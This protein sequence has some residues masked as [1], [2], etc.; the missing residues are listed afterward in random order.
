MSELLPHYADDFATLFH[1]DCLEVTLPENCVDTII[2]DPPYGLGFMG[3]GWDRGVPGPEFWQ[4]FLA[5]TKPGGTLLAF[6]GT[7][8]YHRLASAIEDAGWELRDCLMW[9]YGSGFPKSLDISKALDA[10][11]G[12]EREVVGKYIHP[13]TGKEHGD[14]RTDNDRASY[15]SYAM[16]EDERLLTAPA[17]ELAKLW[18]GYGTA[19]KPAWEPII[20][21]MKP[22]E[23]TFAENAEKWGVAGL[24]IDGARIGTT[25]PPTS[26]KD[27]SRWREMEGRTDSQVAQSDLDTNKGRWPANLLLDEEAAKLLGDPAR[28]FYCAKASKAE[29]EAGLEQMPEV[30]R[31]DGREKDIEN[32]RLRTSSRKNHHPTVKPLA[33]ME[34]LCTLTRTPAGGIVFD[35]FCGS[36]STLI[37]AKRVGRESIGIEL[38]E[39]YCAI[40]A[41]RLRATQPQPKP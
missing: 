40:G 14:F 7:R 26:A 6:G 11:A 5:A 2:S 28:F 10:R 3:K 41:A 35:P 32:P 34:Y 13:G 20:C 29:R 25:R 21:A 16:C 33:L 39:A 17:T 38:D 27:F 37:A 1:G 23:G 30:R 31:T 4:H 24:N 9:L 15:G 36:A 22:L 12:A 19:L 18:D 8:T